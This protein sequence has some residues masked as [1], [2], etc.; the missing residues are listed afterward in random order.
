MVNWGSCL[1]SG[2]RWRTDHAV[3][4]ARSVGHLAVGGEV[5]DVHLLRSK[6]TL[7]DKMGEE[8]GAA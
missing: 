3:A 5:E 1:D 6:G 2:E 7:R 8:V 4:G